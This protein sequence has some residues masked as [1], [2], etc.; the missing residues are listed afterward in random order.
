MN[1]EE[2]SINEKTVGIILY[3]QYISWSQCLLTQSMISFLRIYNHCILHHD[4]NTW[5]WLKQM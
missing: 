3:E 5:N 4:F 2:N 1:K